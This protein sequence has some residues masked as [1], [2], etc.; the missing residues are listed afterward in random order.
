MLGRPDRV[1][2]VALQIRSGGELGQGA[3]REEGALVWRPAALAAPA[4]NTAEAVIEAVE[5][6]KK[7]GTVVSPMTSIHA[8]RPEKSQGARKPRSASTARSP[9]TST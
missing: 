1:N 6:P 8:P 4:P 2:S 3:A 5:A 9:S 7:H